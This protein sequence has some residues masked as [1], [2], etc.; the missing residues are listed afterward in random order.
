MAVTGRSLDAL[1]ATALRSVARE[2]DVFA[3]TTPNPNLRL[4]QALQAEGAVVA[5]TGN[6]VNERPALNKADAGVP[7]GRKG[8]EVAKKA[9]ERVLAV[10]KRKENTSEFQPQ[11]ATPKA[12][13]AW[14]K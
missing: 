8:P 10:N 13:V 3:R 14:K 12:G 7:L 11:R 9:A 2:T 1:D 6:G 4:V 5:M